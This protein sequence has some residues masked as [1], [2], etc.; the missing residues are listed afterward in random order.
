ML[1]HKFEEKSGLAAEQY[2]NWTKYQCWATYR[3]PTNGQH[4]QRTYSKQRICFRF[5]ILM[6]YFFFIYLVLE[7]I[8][9][10]SLVAAN[11]KHMCCTRYLLSHPLLAGWRH[12]CD[13]YAHKASRQR[14]YFER[15]L[16]LIT[17]EQ[18][19]WNDAYYWELKNDTNAPSENLI[20]KK[21]IVYFPCTRR[22]V[23]REKNCIRKN[24]IS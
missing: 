19:K 22:T 1:A 20:D 9:S 13:L 5:T 14:L 24:S 3:P 8:T 4:T 23:S 21:K 18:W 7:M 6:E 10:R 17:W 2:W 12:F 16:S 11:R 15:I